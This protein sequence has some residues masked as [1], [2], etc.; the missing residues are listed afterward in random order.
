VG[1]PPTAAKARSA[2]VLAVAGVQDPI[3][4]IAAMRAGAAT[5][6]AIY[7][8]LGADGGARL[9]EGPGGHHFYPEQAWP[10]FADL[11]GW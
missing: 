5:A 6:A 3:F 8:H 7:R 1:V 11:T 2:G 10:V 9:V 4:P